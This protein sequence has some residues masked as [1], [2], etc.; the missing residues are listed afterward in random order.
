MAGGFVIGI[1]GLEVGGI[2]SRDVV[3]PLRS[4]GKPR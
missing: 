4:N 2:S 3:V 1:V